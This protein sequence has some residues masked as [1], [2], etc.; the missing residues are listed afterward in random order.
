MLSELR[1]ASHVR[2]LRGELIG[3]AVRNGD[4]AYPHISEWQKGEF[5]AVVVPN[6]NSPSPYPIVRISLIYFRS[7]ATYL[8]MP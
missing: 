7:Q 1:E 5:H 6:F 4:D 2:F 3:F 8:L